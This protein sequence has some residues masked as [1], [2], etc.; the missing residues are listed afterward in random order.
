MVGP[1]GAVRYAAVRVQ[2]C[3]DS[4]AGRKPVFAAAAARP[5][6]M[7]FA[8]GLIAAKPVKPCDGDVFGAFYLLSKKEQDAPGAGSVRLAFSEIGHAQQA[9]GGLGVVAGGL[10]RGAGEGEMAHFAA[11]ARL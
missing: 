2:R 11:R 4:A 8:M 3:S 10:G 1:Q 9:G 6:S 7:V 5:E